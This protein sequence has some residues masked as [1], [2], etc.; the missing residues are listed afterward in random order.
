ME[1]VR[2]KS[3]GIEQIVN[4]DKGRAVMDVISKKNKDATI[5]QL[6]MG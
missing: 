1:W 4:V 2:K 6:Q 3:F 5:C